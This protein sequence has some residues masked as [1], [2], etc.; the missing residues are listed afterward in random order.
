MAIPLRVLMVGDCPD[1]AAVILRELE[2][3]GYCV[4]QRPVRSASEMEAALRTD[5]WDLV[6]ADDHASGFDPCCALAILRRY[7]DQ[8]FIVVSD[9]AGED[10][11]A[12]IMKAG[13]NDYVMKDN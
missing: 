13:A 8:P 10:R 7:G 3:G 5:R 6:V 4:H 9:T 2:R 12:Q 1:D 11:A